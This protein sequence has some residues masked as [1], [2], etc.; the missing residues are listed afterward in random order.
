MKVFNPHNHGRVKVDIHMVFTPMDVHE[1][2][3]Q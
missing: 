2:V 3:L 1:G